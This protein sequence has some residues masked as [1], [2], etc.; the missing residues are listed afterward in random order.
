MRSVVFFTVLL[1]EVS[2]LS[3]N[4]SFSR[5]PVDVTEKIQPTVGGIDPGSFGT[6]NEH[7]IFTPTRDNILINNLIVKVSTTSPYL[8]CIVRTF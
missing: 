4:E 1:M 7:A 6:L 8:P 5:T 2:E 3:F